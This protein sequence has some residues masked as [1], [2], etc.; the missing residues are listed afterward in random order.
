MADPNTVTNLVTEHGGR[1]VETLGAIGTAIFTMM[2]G[3][4]AKL[5]KIVELLTEIKLKGKE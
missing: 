3:L 2:R 5:D 4:T 1:F